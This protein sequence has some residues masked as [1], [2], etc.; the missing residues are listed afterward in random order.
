LD[1]LTVGQRALELEPAACCLC[2]TRDS[3]PVA[4]GEDFEYRTSA[5]SFLAVRCVHCGVI[6]LDP[7]PTASELTAI[8][9]DTYHA[10][11]FSPE[12][13]GVVYRTRRALEARRIA[14]ALGNLPPHARVLD[15]GCGD[16]FHLAALRDSG[17][18]AWHL[19]G[20]DVDERAVATAREAGLEVH[21]SRV[22][23]FE[24]D[25]PFDAALLIQTV[26]HVAD[27]VAVLDAIRG[28]LRPGGLLYL[29]TD[30]TGSLDF[31]LAKRRFWGGYHF[32][33]HWYLFDREALTRLAL[34]AG[35]GVESIGTMVSPVNWVYSIRNALDDW[36]AP[37]AFVEWWS[38]DSPIP[39]AAFTVFDAANDVVGAGALLRAVLRAEP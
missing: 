35:F 38:L 9:P 7:R 24:P 12:A 3:E 30:N 22:E 18:A 6:Y 39:L 16:G 10:F 13:Y 28:R 29:V 11:D 20:I 1:D 8:Y 36:G 19:E 25:E 33:R 31:A 17:T 2:R 5:D 34:R 4:V 23:D 15:V 32:P 27:P 21:H 26:E 14:R 37:R